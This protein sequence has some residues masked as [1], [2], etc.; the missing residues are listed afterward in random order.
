MIIERGESA[1]TA[2]EKRE[3]TIAIVMTLASYR[4]DSAGSINYERIAPLCCRERVRCV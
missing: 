3:R 2:H 1:E 4:T